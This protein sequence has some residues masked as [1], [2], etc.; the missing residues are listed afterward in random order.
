[1][2]NDVFRKSLILVITAL[3]IASTHFSGTASII[4]QTNNYSN[5]GVSQL[6]L[7]RI[8]TSQSFN[9]LPSAVEI[10]DEKPG[11]WIDII[12]SD[13]RLNELSDYNYEV[14]IPD[15]IEYDNKVRGEYHTLAEIESILQNI[16]NDYPDI[17]SLYS[18]GT[19]YEDRSIWCL[20][21]TDNP[22]KDESE[23][24]I[25]FT[26]L[27]HANE[28]PSVEICLYIAN[29]LTAQYGSNQSIANIVN[30]RR[31]WLIPCVNPD[32]YYYCHDQGH[33][34]WRKNR[35]PYGSYSGVDLN[36]NYDGSCDGNMWGAWGS[37][38]ESPHGVWTSHE[39]NNDHYCGPSPFSENESQAVANIFLENDIC[40]SITWHTSGEFVLWPWGYSTDL[41]PDYSYL[42]SIGTQIAQRITKMSESGTYTPQQN[43]Y[44]YGHAGGLADW[45]YGYGHYIQGRPTFSYLIET[46]TYLNPHPD[47][48]YLDQICSEN[49]DGAFYLLQEADQ[50]SNTVVPRVLPPIIHRMSNDSDGEYTISWHEQNP[51]ANPQYFQID[52]LTN[53][54]VM[55]DNAELST[56]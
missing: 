27:H 40:A 6:T 46:C 26:G 36:R 5:T 47:E 8:N 48:S 4:N 9:T 30:N 29:Q 28:W 1:M 37:I 43:Y 49:F 24:G 12:I 39:P 38:I 41:T 52:E 45:P 3:F 51:A 35:Q 21:I 33:P 2:Q 50:I 19:T 13:E 10:V 42:E 55:I 7:L 32:G 22:G 25:V 20:E 15:V 14:I 54:T 44:F 34:D 16:A 17:T 31:L 53:L 56:E 11:D 18:I 23:P